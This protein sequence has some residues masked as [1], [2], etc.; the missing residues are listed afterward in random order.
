MRRW[1]A[2]GLLSGFFCTASAQADMIETK[3]DGI[4]NGK[5]LSENGQ[6]VRFQNAKGKTLI[7]KK[8]DILFEDKEDIAKKS[9]QMAQKVWD[10][11]K[12]LPKMIRKRSDQLTEKFIGTVGA[13][14]DRSG[15]NA[16]ADQLNRAMDDANQASAA[17]TKKAAAANAEIARQKNESF[18]SAQSST[19]KKGHFASLDS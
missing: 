4:L 18:G 3:K 7:F 9:K 1:V 8:T 11:L 2:L 19:E 13:P 15:A 10:W 14:L 5:I 17:M 16:K 12:N 6:E